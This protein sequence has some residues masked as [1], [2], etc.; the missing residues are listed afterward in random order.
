[1]TQSAR[2]LEALRKAGGRGVTQID[3]L[4]PNVADGGSPIT[5]VAARVLELKQDGHHIVTDGERDSC[6]V[7]KLVY[8]AE[9]PVEVEPEPTGLFEPKPRNAIF[10]DWEDAA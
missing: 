3:F 1:M 4:I 7:Y 9:T 8:D 6:A 2:V 5:R 10:D